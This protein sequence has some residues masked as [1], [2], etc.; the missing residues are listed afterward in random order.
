MD[1]LP[2]DYFQAFW[3]LYPRKIKKPYAEKCSKKIK[4]D[5]WP[6]VLDG[7]K[8]YIIHWRHAGTEKTYIPHPSSWINNRQWEDEIDTDHDAQKDS[9]AYTF[10]K[11]VRNQSNRSMPDFP[12]EIK[13]A[14]FRMGIP[15]GKLKAL[16]DEEIESKFLVAYRNDPI[17]IR[18]GK[19]AAAGE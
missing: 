16:H 10:L 7:L 5:E 19:A 15:W 14:F 12:D 6:H 4:K 9:H 8:K 2:A 1:D 13:Q 18:D 3:S 11:A 17:V